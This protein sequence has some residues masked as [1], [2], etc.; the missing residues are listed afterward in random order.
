LARKIRKPA[1][2]IQSFSAGAR[3]Q[4]SL[5]E[6]ETLR[7]G[8]PVSQ[9]RGLPQYNLH[10]MIATGAMAAARSLGEPRSA[11]Q[12]ISIRRILRWNARK[13]AL[14]ASRDENFW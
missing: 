8:R 12:S 13:D 14:L 4:G 1:V 5:L 9:R 10:G 7:L 3:G 6:A 2:T 11:Q